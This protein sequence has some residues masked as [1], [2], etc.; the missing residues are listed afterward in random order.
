MYSPALLILTL[1]FPALSFA[2]PDIL[3][4]Q[5]QTGDDGS[6]DDTSSASDD[7]SGVSAT[8]RPAASADSDTSMT[9]AA[10]SATSGTSQNVGNVLGGAGQGPSYTGRMCQL[11]GD[12]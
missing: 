11:R 5:D 2:H 4:R 1:L 3:R 8:A 10:P 6:G 12:I 7:G 9:S